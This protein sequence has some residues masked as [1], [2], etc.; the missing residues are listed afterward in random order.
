MLKISGKDIFNFIVSEFKTNL[1]LVYKAEGKSRI[2]KMKSMIAYSNAALLIILFLTSFIPILFGFR[3]SG[4]FLL[5]HVKAA[6][7]IS[8]TLVLLV[9]LFSNQNQLSMEEL[10]LF[11]LKLRQNKKVNAGIALKIIYWLLIALVLPAMLSIILMLF[12]IFG[13]DGIK[14]LVE[15]HRYSVLL[16]SISV[17]FVQYFRILIEK[18]IHG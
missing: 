11:W 13:T 17:I 1:I 3:M 18:E 6:L 4:L 7:L 5:I 8:V 10:K 2:Q 16:I 15:I 14:L 9:F 12:P